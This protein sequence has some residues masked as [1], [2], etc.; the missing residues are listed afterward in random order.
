MSKKIKI[1]IVSDVVCP[2]CYIGQERLSKAIESSGVDTEINWQPFQLHP[3][4]PT[5]GA[6]KFKF[7]EGKFGGSGEAMF[8]NVE[9]AAKSEGLAFN[10]ENVANI[11]NTVE[12]HRIMHLAK[13]K[14]L[15]SEMALAFFEAYFVNGEDL[16]TSEGILNVAVKGGLERKEAQDYLDSDAGK[17][18]VLGIEQQYKAAG[19]QSVPSFILNDKF[20]IQGAQ[21]PETF[22]QAFEQIE[23]ME[24]ESV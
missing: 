17:Q 12:S 14:G 24:S 22:M 19:I 15:E 3:D 4:L 5:A 6:D 20:L 18:E 10:T 13:S 1:D 9:N 11:P 7:L 21:S 2:W 8:K 23:K 16:T